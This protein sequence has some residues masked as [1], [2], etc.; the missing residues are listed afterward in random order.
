MK[1]AQHSRR[2]LAGDCGGVIAAD[3]PLDLCDLHLAVA[4][5]WALRAD[6]LADLLPAPC[7]ACGSRTG[8]RYPSGWICGICEWRVGDVVDDELPPPRVDVVYYLRYADRVKIGTTGNPRQRFGRIWHD[9]LL[10]FERGG[11]RLEQRRHAQFADDRLGG[12]W[13]RRSPELL[14]H[15]GAVAA[16][17]DDPWDLH[18]RWVSEATAL[19]G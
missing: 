16:G 11:R 12:E 14:E 6:G 13:F 2:C 4:A 9:E 10:G 1:R 5:D 8:V 19:R 3:A 7:R 17:V 18:A 15:V